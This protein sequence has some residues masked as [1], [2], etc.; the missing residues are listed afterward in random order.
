METKDPVLIWN[1]LQAYLV[2][3]GANCYHHADPNPDDVGG[4]LVWNVA[5]GSGKNQYLTLLNSI[6]RSI[7]PLPL[8]C[9]LVACTS[10]L[11][12]PSVTIL[13]PGKSLDLEILLDTFTY[14][15]RPYCITPFSRSN[16]LL[17]RPMMESLPLRATP[18]KPPKGLRLIPPRQNLR[19]SSHAPSLGKRRL[20]LSETHIGPPRRAELRL[21]KGIKPIIWR[22]FYTYSFC[23][24]VLWCGLFPSSGFA[25]FLGWNGNRC[26]GRK[27]PFNV[28]PISIGNCLQLS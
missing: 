16:M 26:D 14:S 7:A 3:T 6:T 20:S 9:L 21:L 17:I 23:L 22:I 5:L 1:R 2:A 13:I 27:L 12:L 8:P 28:N 25:Y 15:H 18:I 19:A 10:D 4:Y 24:A 11:L